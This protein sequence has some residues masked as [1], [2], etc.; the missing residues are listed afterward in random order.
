M[1]KQIEEMV[2]ALY[3]SQHEYDKAWHECLQNN[4][5]RPERKN[6][7]DA[8]YLVEKK[9]YRKQSDTARE[10]FAE[11][12]KTVGQIITSNIEGDNSLVETEVDIVHA[13]AELKKKYGVME[14]EIA[15]L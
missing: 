4:G 6:V 15:L 12:I 10:I 9:G 11:T 1:N 7:F 14:D 8:K 3:E 13:L 5:K 2:I